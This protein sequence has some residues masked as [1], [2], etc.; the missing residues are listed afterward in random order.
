MENYKLFTWHAQL[1]CGGPSFE[2]SYIATT[3][4]EARAGIF[5]QFE[6]I[7][8]ARLLNDCK[9]Q[10]DFRNDTNGGVG[11][12]HFVEGTVLEDD[13][14]LGDHIMLTPAHIQPLTPAYIRPLNLARITVNSY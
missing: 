5:K 8:K 6:E 2:V 7:T 13:T 11:L 12:L 9:I 4:A 14:V 1:F 3:V 10:T